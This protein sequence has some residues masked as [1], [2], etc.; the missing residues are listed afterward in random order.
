MSRTLLCGTSSW[1]PS[2]TGPSPTAVTRR[3][4]VTHASRSVH[5]RA[6][7]GYVCVT[8]FF[9]T[10][11]LMRVARVPIALAGGDGCRPSGSLYAASLSKPKLHPRRAL[12]CHST[13]H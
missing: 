11:T 12:P 10:A 4:W 6:H 3:R 9:A 7:A 2:T 13:A 8:L 5:S 1:S